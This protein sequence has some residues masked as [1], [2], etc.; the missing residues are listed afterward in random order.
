MQRLIIMSLLLTG[1]VNIPTGPGVLVLPNAHVPF[2]QFQKDDVFCRQFSSNQVGGD[3]AK[4]SSSTYITQMRYDN[5][6]M[7]CMYTKGHQIPTSDV[8]R[9]PQY[10]FNFPSPP[11]SLR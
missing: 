6:Y 3:S 7:Q 4:K 11:Y 8:F 9:S 1:C 5:A 10:N 2:E